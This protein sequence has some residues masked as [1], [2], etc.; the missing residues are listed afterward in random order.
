MTKFRIN[1]LIGSVLTIALLTACGGKWTLGPQ[2]QATGFSV[3][4]GS[5]E[6]VTVPAENAAYARQIRMI[7]KDFG[8]ANLTGLLAGAGG[9]V[10]QPS[11]E[12]QTAQSPLADRTERYKSQYQGL[13][14]IATFMSETTVK[15]ETMK[16]PTLLAKSHKTLLSFFSTTSRVFKA[17]QASNEFSRPLKDALSLQVQVEGMSMTQYLNLLDEAGKSL[18]NDDEM[19][20][21]ADFNDGLPIFG[22]DEVFYELKRN[23]LRQQLDDIFA[24]REALL[25]IQLSE[26]RLTSL[27]E[28]ANKAVKETLAIKVSDKSREAHFRLYKLARATAEVVDGLYDYGKKAGFKD[29]PDPA[30]LADSG[31]VYALGF[32]AESRLNLR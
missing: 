2:P 24:T 20:L 27:R 4:I 12:P 16:P 29:Q 14:P 31:L 26:A 18:K 1:L 7:R 23:A 30:A 15:L 28:Q 3:R 6:P 22:I 25:K 10:P 5:D 17:V 13:E 8:R 19:A 9:I 21:R 32:W 11:P